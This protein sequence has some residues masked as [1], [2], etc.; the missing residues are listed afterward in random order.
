MKR[1]VKFGS[2]VLVVAILAATAVLVFA[3]TVNR[4]PYGIAVPAIYKYTPSTRT[5]SSYYLYPPALSA[6]DEIVG[7]DASQTLTNKILTSPAITGGTI[8]GPAI[9]DPNIIDGWLE[10][11]DETEATLTSTSPDWV[12]VNKTAGLSELTVNLPTITTAL[13]GKIFYFKQIDSGTTAC[14]VT[15]TAGA[16]AIEST[17]GT[18]TATSDDTIDAAGDLKGWKAHYR[19]GASPVWLLIRDDIT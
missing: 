12:A 2:A 15:P 3:A 5:V 1:P 6:N 16:D 8:A 13:D 10:I 11:G 14:V 18:L 17:Q 4:Y 7:K 9:T 19:S